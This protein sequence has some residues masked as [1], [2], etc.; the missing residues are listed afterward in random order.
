MYM[1]GR[2]RGRWLDTLATYT[3]YVPS[4][5][6]IPTNNKEIYGIADLPIF[7]DIVCSAAMTRCVCCVTWFMPH[8][9][10]NRVIMA[11]ADGLVPAGTRSSATTMMAQGVRYISGGL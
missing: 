4:W 5:E 7:A 2:E 1:I 6:D 10:H 8:Y 9:S 3:L 11:V